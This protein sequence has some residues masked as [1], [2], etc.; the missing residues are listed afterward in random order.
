MKKQCIHCLVSKVLR[1]Y[2]QN[3]KRCFEFPVIPLTGA[4][5]VLWAGDEYIQTEDEA[6][7]Q[8]WQSFKPPAETLSNYLVTMAVCVFRVCVCLG[9]E[10]WR[11]LLLYTGMY[12]HHV[13]ARP[14]VCGGASVMD[15]AIPGMTFSWASVPVYVCENE[16]YVCACAWWI[17]LSSQR[18]DDRADL[19]MPKM[20]ECSGAV[21]R[22]QMC[23]WLPKWESWDPNTSEDCFYSRGG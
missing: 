14:S 5:S 12:V 23:F 8:T 13:W 17:N 18:Q 2:V 6:L 3:L 7:W 9:C 15:Q 19:E 10:C 1:L 11:K 22:F 21:T 16:L 20:G 4:K